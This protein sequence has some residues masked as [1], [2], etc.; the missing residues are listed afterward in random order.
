LVIGDIFMN[1]TQRNVVKNGH[2]SFCVWDEQMDRSY[3]FKGTACYE[4]SSAAYEVA[5]QNLHQKKPDK[6]FRGVIVVVIT[7]VYDAF[8]GPN[9]GRLIATA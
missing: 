9:A 7:E 6:N 2:V 1:A 3:K 4:M 5:N 8:C